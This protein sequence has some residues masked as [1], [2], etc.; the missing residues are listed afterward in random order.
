MASRADTAERHRHG[1]DQNR[2]I[3]TTLT[4]WPNGDAFTC[5][6]SRSLAFT[7]SNKLPIVQKLQGCVEGGREGRMK[8]GGGVG[9]RQ[10][11]RKEGKGELRT[12]VSRRFVSR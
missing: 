9:V 1:H 7:A 10:K 11:G 6:D 12:S 4:W 8:E 2:A 5:R 3:N